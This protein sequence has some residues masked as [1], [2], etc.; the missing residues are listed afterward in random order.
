[1][2]NQMS[3]IVFTLC[4]VFLSGCGSSNQPTHVSVVSTFTQ[5]P[6]PSAV[7]PESTPSPNAI[8]LETN[9]KKIALEFL[10]N[11]NSVQLSGNQ[12]QWTVTLK[13][14]PFTL[15]VH[16]E[17]DVVSIMALKSTEYLL[18]LRQITKPLVHSNATSQGFYQNNLYLEDKPLEILEM[19]DS[20]FKEAYGLS[21]QEITDSTNSLVAQ[22]GAEP[23]ALT[24]L[25]TY[26]GDYPHFTIETINQNPIKNGESI[27]LVVFADQKLEQTSQKVKWDMLKWLIFKIEF[28]SN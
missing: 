28:I 4:I 8:F 5:H 2:K 23:L 18:T 16:G 3:L 9:G 24:T 14:G 15:M 20:V 13:P 6:I 17:K 26:L 27:I 21:S 1:M 12:E 11:G 25:R 19:S 22:L 7:I 10:Q